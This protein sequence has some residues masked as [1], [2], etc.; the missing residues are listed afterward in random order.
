MSVAMTGGRGFLGWHTRAALLETSTPAATVAVGD[1]FDEEQ[2]A[3]AV[4]GAER[5]I[6]AAGVNRG[7]EDEVRGGNELFA[8]QLARALRRSSQ[9]PAV[10]VYCNSTQSANGSAYGD[11]K[12]AASGI[13]AEAASQVG[14]DFVDVRLP[15]LFGEHGRPH[16]N[17]VTATFCHL[18]ATGGRPEVQVDRELD[19]LHVQDAADVL[20]GARS[21]ADLPRLQRRESV[22]GLLERLGSIAQQYAGGD[23]PDIGDPFSR[24]LFNTYRSYTFAE[25]GEIPFVRHADARG[26]FFEIV[27]S[28]G[29]TAQSSFSTTMP[30]IAR[31]DHFHRRK[32]ERFAVLSGRATISLRKVLT[33]EVVR[34]EVSGEEPV[35]VDMPTMWA[36]RIENT[37]TEPL[38]TAFWTNDIFDPEHPDTIPEAV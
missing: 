22:T 35:G 32:V 31:G 15:N 28:H 4:A 29:G 36:H 5:V 27:R 34:F 37:G 17:S 7:T 25:R 33:D 6:H 12:L 26:S 9:P 8:S 20:I 3:A 1:A 19:L 10:V 23:I 14:A 38:Y 21:V 16:Y 13:L 11:A 30:G 2:A 24:D 18:L